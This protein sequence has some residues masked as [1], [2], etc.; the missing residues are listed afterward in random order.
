QPQRQELPVWR[1]GG[2][3]AIVL[4]RSRM[5]G[6]SSPEFTSVT[7]LPGRG[8][9][10]LQITAFVP[11]KGEINLLASPTVEQAVGI[12]TGTGP[13]ATGQASLQMGAAFEAPW[14][15]TI[16]GTSQ[17]AAAHVSTNWRGHSINVP[18][19]RPSEMAADGGLL[20]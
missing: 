14:A 20:L 7:M 9:N 8:M 2:Q 13:D 12:L 18:A 11:G 5:I 3:D 17:S 10:V 16:W 4:T 15:D 19:T 6:D 1:P